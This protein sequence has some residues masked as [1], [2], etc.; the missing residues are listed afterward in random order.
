MSLIYDY[1]SGRYFDKNIHELAIR[2]N[3]LNIER[4]Y[5]KEEQK[6]KETEITYNDFM[7][8]LFNAPRI[9]FGDD[10]TFNMPI[11]CELFNKTLPDGREGIIMY[12]TGFKGQRA[13]L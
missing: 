8:E 1:I 7:S 6:W 9:L 13:Q 4:A 10:I 5:D 11:N 3:E 12:I 2:E